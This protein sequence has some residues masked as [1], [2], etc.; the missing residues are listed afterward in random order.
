MSVYVCV[1]VC[2]FWYEYAWVGVSVREFAVQCINENMFQSLN[3]NNYDNNN[4]NN[5]KSGDKWRP[6]DH[7][8]IKIGQN[9]EKSP[10]DLRR[11]AVS[12]TTV[13]SHQL[14]LI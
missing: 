11:F 5:W 3:N 6:I 7:S 8:I 9:T 13:K 2:M 10:G 12:Q 14:T 4:D 1:Y